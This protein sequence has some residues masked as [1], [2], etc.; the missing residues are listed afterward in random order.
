MDTDETPVPDPEREEL[1]STMKKASDNKRELERIYQRI[2]D[3][4]KNLDDKEWRVSAILSAGYTANNNLG[5]I[6]KQDAR[7]GQN[8]QSHSAAVVE[9]ARTR[10]AKNLASALTSR[11]NAAVLDEAHSVKNTFSRIHLSISRMQA[12]FHLFLSATLLMNRVSDIHAYLLLARPLSVDAAVHT[13][14][15]DE[16]KG[17]RSSQEI[18]QLYRNAEVEVQAGTMNSAKLLDP[19]PITL[20]M[21]KQHMD[22]NSA[23]EVLPII[24]NVF[25]IRRLMGQTYET[26]PGQFV[27]IGDGIPTALVSEI[28]LPRLPASQQALYTQSNQIWVSE[29]HKVVGRT[30]TSQGEELGG[31]NFNAVRRMYHHVFMPALFRLGHLVDSKDKVKNL[32]RWL[33]SPKHGLNHLLECMLDDMPISP[34]RW[35]DPVFLAEV[36][37]G[38]SVKLQT[39][40][41][42]IKYHCVDRNE[43]LIIFTEWQIPGWVTELFVMLFG[44]EIACIRSSTKPSLR[45][46][47]CDEFNSEHGKIQ[48]GVALQAGL[49]NHV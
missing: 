22:F 17:V 20:L 26:K 39:L 11:F 16:L 34:A 42:I 21:Q 4:V 45:S 13:W 6:I 8:A 36:F 30:R 40:A 43:R 5:C 25:R 7:R 3:D 38:K 35:D 47:I 32:G 28:R 12:E 37:A 31:T 9:E 48:V 1:E 33:T 49:S 14:S 41:T 19:R 24:W 10:L 15:D 44:L 46:E 18:L 2:K 29:L 27:V 23:V